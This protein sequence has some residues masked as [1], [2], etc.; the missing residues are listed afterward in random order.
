MRWRSIWYLLQDTVLYFIIPNNKSV[1][2]LTVCYTAVTLLDQFVEQPVDTWMLRSP[3][4]AP[5][6]LAPHTRTVI[7][8]YLTA[9]T[10][11]DQFVEQPVDTWMLRSPRY[12]PLLL[13]PHTRTLAISTNLERWGDRRQ[14]D[15][16]TTPLPTWTTQDLQQLC[17]DI[18]N[19]CKVNNLW[20]LIICIVQYVIFK[21]TIN[22]V[23]WINNKVCTVCTVHYVILLK[24]IIIMVDWIIIILVKSVFR[25]CAEI[26]NK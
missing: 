5:L 6:L 13:A 20:G 18:V 22:V 8:Y 4:Y 16:V 2:L 1:Y 15:G 12:A 7:Y 9:V 26:S 21:L 17:D 25:F 10:L 3:R 14:Q 24:L 23:D 11:L 19:T